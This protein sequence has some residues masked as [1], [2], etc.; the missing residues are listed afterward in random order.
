MLPLQFCQPGWLPSLSPWMGW[1]HWTPPCSSSSFISPR[2]RRDLGAKGLF[3]SLVCSVL[4]KA[5]PWWI[6]KVEE[7]VEISFLKKS[8]RAQALVCSLHP[9]LPCENYTGPTSSF[10]H[11]PLLPGK[12][13]HT[14]LERTSWVNKSRRSCLS[15]HVAFVWSL[16]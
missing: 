1:P 9:L 14:E 12:Q 5:G 13:R 10:T 2:N 7:K 15:K 4:Q 3:R 11:H 8:P 16:S 6:S